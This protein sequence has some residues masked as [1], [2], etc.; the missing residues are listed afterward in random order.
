[1]GT[2]TDRVRVEASPEGA[3]TPQGPDTWAATVTRMGTTIT[4]DAVHATVLVVDARTQAEA[5]VGY[6]ADCAGA[7]DMRTDE[8]LVRAVETVFECAQAILTGSAGQMIVTGV[9]TEVE[10]FQAARLRLT[11]AITNRVP[12]PASVSTLVC[13]GVYSAYVDRASSY[14]AHKGL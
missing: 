2:G 5:V 8:H 4:S 11:L 7:E 14:L 10:V 6:L 13:S 1:M 3:S 12:D 9:T